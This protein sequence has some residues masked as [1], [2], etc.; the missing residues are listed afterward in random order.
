MNLE[1]KQKS[2]GNG[3]ILK[4]YHLQNSDLEIIGTQWFP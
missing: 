3:V 4:T 2:V 1:A